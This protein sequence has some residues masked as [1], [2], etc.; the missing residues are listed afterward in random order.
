VIGSEG[1]ESGGEVVGGSSCTVTHT[2]VF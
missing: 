2:R 1:V